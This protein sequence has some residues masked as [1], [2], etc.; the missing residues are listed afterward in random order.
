MIELSLA[1]GSSS[2]LVT[3]GAVG[4]YACEENPSSYSNKLDEEEETGWLEFETV[5]VLSRKLTSCYY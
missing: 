1:I 4:G 3:G 2:V 5:G